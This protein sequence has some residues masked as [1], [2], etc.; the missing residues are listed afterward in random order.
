MAQELTQDQLNDL[1][2]RHPIDVPAIMDQLLTMPLDRAQQ[3]I[4]YADSV[5]G[6]VLFSID[7]SDRI[8]V[9]GNAPASE[10]AYNAP[11]YTPPDQP[12]ET[13]VLGVCLD[14][15]ISL[16]RLALFGVVLYFLMK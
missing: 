7:A 10:S 11:T 8:H 3:G 5:Y 15:P 6:T 13:E 16:G 2:A 14:G 12:C 9:V 4:A 1:I